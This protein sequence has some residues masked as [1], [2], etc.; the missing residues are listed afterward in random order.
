M[1]VLRSPAHTPIRG[2]SLLFLGDPDLNDTVCQDPAW[3]TQL[4]SLFLLAPDGSRYRLTELGFVPATHT[5]GSLLTWAWR[6]RN[7]KQGPW[8]PWAREFF[9]DS[10][11]FNRIINF[12]KVLFRI[13]L[14]S[15]SIHD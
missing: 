11:T 10:F 8:K 9:K 3:N 6:W 14:W 7:K 4:P 2:G 1:W 5:Q 12:S 15:V 13:R